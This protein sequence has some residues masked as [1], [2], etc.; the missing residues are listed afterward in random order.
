M[1]SAG[2]PKDALRAVSSLVPAGDDQ[3]EQIDDVI[4]VQMRQEHGI[5]LPA[6]AA[7]SEQPLRHT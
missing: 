7:G 5:R 6:A 1:A 2:R 3:L 4:R